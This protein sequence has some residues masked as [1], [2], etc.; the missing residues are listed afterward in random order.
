MTRK[1]QP[2]VFVMGIYFERRETQVDG[3]HE[4]A[5]YGCS[6]ECQIH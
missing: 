5:E 1:K 6:G 2:L 3:R 4:Y